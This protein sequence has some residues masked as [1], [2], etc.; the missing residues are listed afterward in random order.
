MSDLASKMYLFGL[1]ALLS[2]NYYQGCIYT[3]IFTYF[4]MTAILVLV[5][6]NLIDSVTE[7]VRTKIYLVFYG[8]LFMWYMGIMID[9]YVTWKGV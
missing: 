2:L 5:A 3:A 7:N 1:G 4:T 9:Y 6:V 8:V